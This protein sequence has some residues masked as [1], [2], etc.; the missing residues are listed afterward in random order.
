MKHTKID[1]IAENRA[2]FSQMT[3]IA[4]DAYA[5][6]QDLCDQ[7]LSLN[8]GM[9]TITANRLWKD[10]PYEDRHSIVT[11]A[12]LNWLAKIRESKELPPS[13]A[14]FWKCVENDSKISLW[15]EK[16]TSASYSTQNRRYHDADADPVLSPALYGD[17]VQSVVLDLFSSEHRE[18][19][20]DP[21]DLQVRAEAIDGLKQL[22]QTFP[23]EIQEALAGHWNTDDTE[24]TRTTYYRNRRKGLDAIAFYLQSQGYTIDDLRK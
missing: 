13:M 5:A 24:Q 11:V 14:Y 1:Y 23:E 2:L 4:D 9:V 17:A 3:E 20:E 8:K 18:L 10:T 21:A 6:W 22:V 7:F 12:T 19:T 16:G 15:D